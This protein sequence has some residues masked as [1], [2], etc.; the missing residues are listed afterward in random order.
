MTKSSRGVLNFVKNFISAEL[1]NDLSSTNF[2]ESVWVDIK[3][4]DKNILIGGSYRS[5]NSTLGNTVF[6]FELVD[7]VRL[8][9]CKRKI[10]IGD[11][12]FP[13]I[14]WSS[15]TTCTGEN[16]NS[17]RF[18]ECARHNFLEQS[19]TQPTRWRHLNPSNVLDLVLA[20]SVDLIKKVEIT[21]RLGNSDHLCTEIELD[22]SIDSCYKGIHS[23]NYY[24]GN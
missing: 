14:D 18:L 16:H 3:I 23:R 22:T 10:I 12:N 9:K 15:W 17:F 21:A 8:E 13:E 2:L 24:R 6:L 5:P 20:D 11:F 4:N 1:R 7:R 19:I